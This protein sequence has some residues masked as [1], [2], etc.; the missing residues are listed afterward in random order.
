MILMKNFMKDSELLA[1]L[2]S[3][4]DEVD[5]LSADEDMEELTAQ[6]EDAVFFLEQADDEEDMVEATEELSALTLELQ[7]HVVG[8]ETLSILACRMIN[9]LA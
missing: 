9:L 5:A 4:L 2:N 7:Q 8:N 1:Q 3:L 6:L